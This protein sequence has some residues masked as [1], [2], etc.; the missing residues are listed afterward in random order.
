MDDRVEGWTGAGGVSGAGQVQGGREEHSRARES[1]P[2]SSQTDTSIDRWGTART[3]GSEGQ[4]MPPVRRGG[5]AAHRSHR[6][7]RWAQPAERRRRRCAVPG[8]GDAG[9]AHL[10][11]FCCTLSICSDS[12][13]RFKTHNNV[14]VC[15]AQNLDT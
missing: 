6:L 4:T 8:Q 3:T 7:R 1:L 15:S 9:M 5:R 13:A 11:R 2:R 10:L 12:A 14:S